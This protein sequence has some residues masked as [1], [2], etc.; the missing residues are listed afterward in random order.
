MDTCEKFKTVQNVEACQKKRF[1]RRCWASG[2]D[3][4]VALVDMGGKTCILEAE[5][6]H[7]RSGK[8]IKKPELK[9]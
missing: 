3:M 1:S 8:I 9:T 2:T 7:R 5:S 4:Y 6:K